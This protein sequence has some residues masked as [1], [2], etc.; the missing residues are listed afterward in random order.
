MAEG[1][2]LLMS[3][4]VL[5][6]DHYAVLSD[7]KENCVDGIIVRVEGSLGQWEYLPIM[8]E[9]RE[10]IWTRR[11]GSLQECMGVVAR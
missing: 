3:R 8:E 11:V 9:D 4:I 2:L 5:V 7:N 1:R 6:K 10:V